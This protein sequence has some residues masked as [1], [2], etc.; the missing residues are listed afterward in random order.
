MM[1]EIEQLCDRLGIEVRRAP[2]GGEGGGLCS[3]KGRHILYFDTSADALT[4]VERSIS[5]LSSRSEI[6]HVQIAPFLRDA[7]NQAR[8]GG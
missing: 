7:L 2:L 3:I 4:Q 6:D 1:E 8:H 5:D